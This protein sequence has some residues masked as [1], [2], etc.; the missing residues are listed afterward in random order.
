MIPCPACALVAEMPDGTCPN[1]N[2]PRHAIV[3]PAFDRIFGLAHPWS[4]LSWVQGYTLFRAARR[5]PAGAFAEL[6]VYKGGSALMLHL[7]DPSRPLHLFDTFAGHPPLW[8]YRHDRPGSHQPGTLGDTD[9][10]VVRA[11]LAA[12]GAQVEL[13]VGTFP[14]SLQRPELVGDVAYGRTLPPLALVHVDVD[15]WAS[16]RAALLVFG[17]HLV[18]GGQL[19]LD[20]Y[21]TDECPGVVQALDEYLV[22]HDQEFTVERVQ[23][24]T[25]QAVLTRVAE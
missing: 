18:R 23:H 17:R 11:R 3:D 25:Y 6:G 15:L 12:A 8:D 10:E 9:A 20:D 4:L 7:A 24:P 19:V 16:A 5:V 13:W 21:G 22:M 14:E 1:N 2:C